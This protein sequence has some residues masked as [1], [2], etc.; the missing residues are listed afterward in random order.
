M[1]S[2]ERPEAGCGA[3]AQQREQGRL[4][5][6]RGDDRDDGD[7]ETGKAEGT[8]ERDRDDQ[9]NGKADRHSRTGDDDG[10]AGGRHRGDDGVGVCELCVLQL[11]FEPVDDEQAVVDR[12][13]EADELHEVRDVEDH[14][15]TV[16]EEEHDRE[17]GKGRARRHEEREEQGDGQPED[18]REQS[19]RD[20][21]RQQLAPSQVRRRGSG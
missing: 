15:E 17:R 11:L 3:S 7:D 20:H 4:Q 5:R 10:P 18:E 2:S 14:Q 12:Q 19:Q 13:A 1:S 21:H 16:R 8:D 6:E 9:E